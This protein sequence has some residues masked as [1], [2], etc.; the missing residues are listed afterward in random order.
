MDTLIVSMLQG[1][2]APAVGAATVVFLYKLNNTA[3]A[4]KEMM[5]EQKNMMYKLFHE[6]DKRVTVIES[7]GDKHV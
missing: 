6:L 3:T 2:G 5:N 1:F 7:K 4:Q